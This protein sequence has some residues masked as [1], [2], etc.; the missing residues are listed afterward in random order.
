MTNKN[1]HRTD[2]TSTDLLIEGDYANR[3]WPRFTVIRE[4][5]DACVWLGTA[6]GTLCARDHTPIRTIVLQ[7]SKYEG[8]P[9]EEILRARAK[10]A[11]RDAEVYFA[12]FP[13]G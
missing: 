13:G 4:T 3:E 2:L 10:Y 7:I 11:Y 12:L 1:H 6:R 8:R 5:G 9:I